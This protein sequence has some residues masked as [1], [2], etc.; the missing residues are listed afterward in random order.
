MKRVSTIVVSLFLIFSLYACESRNI[1]E[2]KEAFG[3]GEYRNVISLLEGEKNIDSE[4]SGMLTISK[5]NVAFSNKDYIEAIKYL[6]NVKNGTHMNTYSESVQRCIEKAV[7][8]SDADLLAQLISADNSTEE[9]I[10]TTLIDGCNSLDFKYFNILDSVINSFDE[11]DMKADL[12]EYRDSNKINRAK[13]FLIGEWELQSN[14]QI[15][16]VVKIQISENELVGTVKQV[17]ENE[18]QYK[19]AVS[20][21]YWKKFAFVDE[22]TFSCYNLMKT[23]NGNVLDVPTVGEINYETGSIA[24]YLNVPAPYHTSDPNRIWKKTTSGY[25]YSK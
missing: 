8:T 19:I 18:A 13:A 22:N 7:K 23:I 9:K 3:N 15:K 4:L 1:K 14:T 5:A 20:D 10:K 25:I 21:T 11:T 24:L 2:A 17:S 16:T 12:I 6:S